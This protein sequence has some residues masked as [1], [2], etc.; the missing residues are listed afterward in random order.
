MSFMHVIVYLARAADKWFFAHTTVIAS[1][2][3]TGVLLS[4]SGSLLESCRD[5]A[6]LPHVAALNNP[7]PTPHLHPLF[8][9]VQRWSASASFRHFGAYRLKWLDSNTEVQHV[10]DRLRT[11]KA[12][13]HAIFVQR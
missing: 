9:F 4:Y 10:K 2:Y 11:W 6:T 12:L 8:V 7:C 13:S 3:L 5:I 1:A